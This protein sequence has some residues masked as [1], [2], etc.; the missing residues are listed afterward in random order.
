MHYENSN[1]YAVD[2]FPVSACDTPRITRARIF[3]GKEVF[4]LEKLML[5]QQ[6]GVALRYLTLFLPIALLFFLKRSL[7]SY[8]IK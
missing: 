4:F 1:E 3:Q 8:N 6:K 2:S 7:L 5:L